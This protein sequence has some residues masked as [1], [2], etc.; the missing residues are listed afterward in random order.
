MEGKEEV[1]LGNFPSSP[2]P[3]LFSLAPPM[4]FEGYFSATNLLHN[5]H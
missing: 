5:D 3:P 1:E 4:V 2:R